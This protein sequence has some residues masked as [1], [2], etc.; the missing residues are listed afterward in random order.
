MPSI[1]LGEINRDNWREACKLQVSEAQ[2]N[3]VAPNWYSIIEAG[4][5]GYTTHAIYDGE[6]M[7][8]FLMYGYDPDEKAYWIIRLM[9]DEKYQ[10]KGYGRAAMQQLIQIF[11]SKPDCDEIFI[12]FEPVNDIARKLYSDLGFVDTGRIEYGETVYK[13]SLDRS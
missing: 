12:S 8:G 11:Q 3:F 4:Y 2:K 10:G 5:E 9:V 7:V 13:L 1:T 6:L